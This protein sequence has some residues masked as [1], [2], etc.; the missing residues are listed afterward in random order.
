MLVLVLIFQL[1]LDIINKGADVIVID[2]QDNTYDG[3]PFYSGE[4]W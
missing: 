3:T 4:L 1:A 2:N